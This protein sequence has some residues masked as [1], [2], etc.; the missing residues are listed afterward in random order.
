MATI[1]IE[2]VPEFDYSYREYKIKYRITLDAGE[3]LSSIKVTS[4]ANWCNIKNSSIT[5][6][7]TEISLSENYSLEGRDAIITIEY[8]TSKTSYS[9]I[10]T[11]RQAGFVFF[12]IWQ[13]VDYSYNTINESVNYNINRDSEIIYSGKA[14]KMPLSEDINININ[15]CSSSFLNS[16]IYNAF[17][18]NT[19]W[20]I[21][22]GVGVFGLYIN[23]D[24]KSKYV[25]YN[26][27]SYM[28]NPA[29][30]NDGFISLSVPIRKEF[31]SRQY[32][33][34]SFFD[35]IGGTVSKL[36]KCIYHYS[37]TTSSLTNSVAPR[38]EYVFTNKIPSGVLKVQFFDD[39]YI[40]KT[41][42]SK[43]CLYYVNGYGGWDSFLIN[44]NDKRTDKLTSYTYVK[45]CNNNT[46]EFGSKKYLNVVKPTYELFT[47]WLNDDESSR[48]WHL[49]ESTEVYL[50]NLETDK[51]I[52]VNITN[53]SVDYKTFTNNGKK[54]YY[55]KISVEESQTK[56]RK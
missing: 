29:Y 52:P 40:V 55:Y 38:T 56:I 22:E 8:T 28:E 18:N 20:N 26:S 1:V 53:N 32:A 25:F 21:T 11:I 27:Y 43:Y 19:I 13:D 51:I 5:Y 34:Y 46:T 54:K 47:D 7:S 24:F 42:C 2:N 10:V 41:G 14:Y 16:S 48:M 3:T 45:S 49:L 6:Y 50:H 17:L 12:P 39:E 36:A 4:S 44:G 30:K 31:D 37:N 9:T 33:V 35:A 15:K 23:D